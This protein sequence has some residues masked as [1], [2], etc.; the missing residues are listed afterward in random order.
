[1]GCSPGGVGERCGLGGG[2]AVA[3]WG[4]RELWSGE[5]EGGIVWSVLLIILEGLLV[6]EVVLGL[7]GLVFKMWLFRT[8]LMLARG[9][10]SVTVVCSFRF[11]IGLVGEEL[12]VDWKLV[13]A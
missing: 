11:G 1:M 8:L 4:S 12:F 3:R 13:L 5:P 7:V 2:A 9:S 6:V 10:L